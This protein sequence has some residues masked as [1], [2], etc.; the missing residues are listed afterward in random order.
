M[1]QTTRQ[2]ML[3]MNMFVDE[4]L[5]NAVAPVCETETETATEPGCLETRP[6]CWTVFAALTKATCSCG[7]CYP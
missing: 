7:T 4:L 2:T 6:S 5:N 3:E 1:A